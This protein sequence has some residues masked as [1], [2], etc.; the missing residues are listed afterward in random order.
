MTRQKQESAL[1][2]PL[3]S[4]LCREHAKATITCAAMY[5]CKRENK[6]EKGQKHTNKNNHQKRGDGEGNYKVHSGHGAKNNPCVWGPCYPALARILTGGGFGPSAQEEQPNPHLTRAK[7]A[8]ASTRG[9]SCKQ[10]QS[11]P[12]VWKPNTKHKETKRHN[13]K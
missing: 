13:K 9:A 10:V 12:E 11:P 6:Q 2:S 5:A 3:S 8:G 1:S 7:G 4:S